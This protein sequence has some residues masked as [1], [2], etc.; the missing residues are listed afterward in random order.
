[1]RDERKQKE[2]NEP[3]YLEVHNTPNRNVVMFFILP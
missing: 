1:M 2:W 3:G